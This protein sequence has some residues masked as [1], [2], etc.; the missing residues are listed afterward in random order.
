MNAWRD[1]NDA[2]GSPWTEPDTVAI[3]HDALATFLD[4]VFGYCDGLIP[5]RGF[6]DVGQDRD[7]RPHNIWIPADA[8]AALAGYMINANAIGKAS[9]VARYGRPKAN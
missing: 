9:F 6:V 3:N 7:T 1:F 8:T 4:V 5:V 2:A